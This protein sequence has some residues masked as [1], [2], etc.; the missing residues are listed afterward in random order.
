MN[1]EEAPVADEEYDAFIWSQHVNHI[2]G[3]TT[4]QQQN[5]THLKR[6]TQQEGTNEGESP[7]DSHLNSQEIQRIQST[8]GNS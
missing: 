3:G 7:E 8:R 4:V 1:S 6:R 2:N 5:I